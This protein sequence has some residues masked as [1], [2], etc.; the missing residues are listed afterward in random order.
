MVTVGDG[1]DEEDEDL[2]L[3]AAVRCA[4][5]A[6]KLITLLATFFEIASGSAA[7]SRFVDNGSVFCCFVDDDVWRLLSE[8]MSV[9]EVEAEAKGARL[10]CAALDETL[11]LGALLGV[12]RAQV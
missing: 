4:D 8:F 9:G 6:A 5:G 2:L 12:P 11:E 10:I 7:S 1:C 3:L